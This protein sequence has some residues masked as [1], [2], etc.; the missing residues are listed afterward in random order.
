MLNPLTL[1]LQ[2]MKTTYLQYAIVFLSLALFACNKIELKENGGAKPIV[3]SYLVPGRPIEV[4]IW[5]EIMYESGDTILDIID[6][7]NVTVTENAVSTILAQDPTGNYI[8]TQFIVSEGNTYTIEF[9]YQGN[10][11]SAQTQIP[12][13]PLNYSCNITQFSMSEMRSMGPQNINPVTLSWVAI[14][15]SYF[16]TI[17]ENVESSPIAINTGMPNRPH[18]FRNSPVQGNNFQIPMPSF[19]YY[20]EHR[21]ILYKLNPE[22]AA[23]YENNGSS[24]LNLTSPPGNISNGLGIFTGINADTLYINV[25]E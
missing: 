8:S 11:I 4:K 12:F 22:Y 14:D 16:L 1:Y 19:S 3:E 6:N 24:S 17:V 21:V 13:Q 15:N 9:E 18:V 7:L 20:G 23:L 25:I 5:K 2:K 10:K